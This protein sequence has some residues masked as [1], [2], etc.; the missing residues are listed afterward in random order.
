[1]T[2]GSPCMRGRPVLGWAVAI[3][4]T[5]PIYAGAVIEGQATLAA[6]ARRGSGRATEEPQPAAVGRSFVQQLA[7][8][9][10]AATATGPGVGDLADLVLGARAC[11]DGVEDLILGDRVTQAHIHRG[12]SL[13][14]VRLLRQG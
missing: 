3:G 7:E 9:L 10:Q 2:S 6:R 12:R 8:A 13:S 14:V 4:T 11:S 5:V 1:M